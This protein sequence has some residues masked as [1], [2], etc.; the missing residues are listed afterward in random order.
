MKRRRVDVTVGPTDRL[1]QEA[2]R[3][4]ASTQRRCCVRKRAECGKQIS[5]VE[6]WRQD[7]FTGVTAHPVEFWQ[8]G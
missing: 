2:A 7:Y 6:V 8:T 3:R 5:A 1:P 4:P